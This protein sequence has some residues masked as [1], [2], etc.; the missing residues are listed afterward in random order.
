MQTPFYVIIGSC[1][2]QLLKAEEIVTGACIAVFDE[3]F[4]NM[5]QPRTIT[6]MEYYKQLNIQLIIVVPTNHSQSIIPY[7]DTV[8][9]L[10]KKDN[11]INEA[12]LYNNG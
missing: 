1:F 12:Y 10:V 2:N 11:V 5:D 8:V 6:L 7:V 9:S 4:N 3:A